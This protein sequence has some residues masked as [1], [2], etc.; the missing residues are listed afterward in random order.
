MTTSNEVLDVLREISHPEIKRN[1]V[2]LGMIKDVAIENDGA[3][4]ILALP[5]KGI[6]IG[7]RLK[8]EVREAIKGIDP[9]LKVNLVVVEMSQK[10]RAV[11][12]SEAD[13]GPKTA[14]LQNKIG[15]VIAVLSGKGGVGKSSVASLLAVALSR[16]KKRVGVLDADITGPSIPKMFGLTKPPMMSESGI[17]PVETKMGIKIMSINLLL[18]G[19]DE[20]VIWRGPRI[21]GAI[22]QFWQDVHWGELDY[23]IVDLPPG[24]SDA[25][26][27]VMQSIPLGGI[28][29]VTS[30]Q[31]LAG[32]VVRKAAG[33]A[34][35]LGA[36]I[37]G[38]VE[39]MSHVTCPKCGMRIL[40]FGPSRS[41][42]TAQQL[43]VPLLGQLP[44]DPLL[45]EKCDAGEIE[46][47]QTD[48]FL[49][50]AEAIV[51]R[52]AKPATAGTSEQ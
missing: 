32:M 21:S 17:L 40:V 1:L 25:S 37:L 15:N 35:H 42:A 3:K 11:F 10:E 47:Y 4:V 5:Y 33:M 8:R 19:E 16:Q 27:T 24:T 31:D 26:L 43:F 2:E 28:V 9:N 52:I 12:M 18:P 50:I 22:K 48:E 38:M 34:R 29:L 51:N 41:A 36:P 30:P 46:T 45:A 20:A 23:L 14:Q 13:G 7:D 44:L 49:P 39:N 6:P